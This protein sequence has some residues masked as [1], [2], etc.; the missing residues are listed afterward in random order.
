MVKGGEQWS[1]TVSTC[2]FGVHFVQQ[3][4]DG[5]EVDTAF[6][7]GGQHFHGHDTVDAASSDLYQDS[8]GAGPPILTTYIYYY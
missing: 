5:R 8:D 1:T 3:T 6:Q 7:P 2:L 4:N